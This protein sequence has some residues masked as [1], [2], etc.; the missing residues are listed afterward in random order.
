MADSCPSWTCGTPRLPGGI[1]T[2]CRHSAWAPAD[3]LL[4]P[5]A[6]LMPCLPSWLRPERMTMTSPAG[7]ATALPG[8]WIALSHS[9]LTLSIYPY[10]IRDVPYNRLCLLVFGYILFVRTVC[11]V[12]RV[13]ST[14]LHGKVPGAPGP[15]SAP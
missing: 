4:T 1:V 10:P 14:Y 6:R 9:S 8:A 12:L 3:R 13:R 11:S 5:V 7:P 15:T 2:T